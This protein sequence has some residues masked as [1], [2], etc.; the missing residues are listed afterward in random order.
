MA[1]KTTLTFPNGNRY[2]GEINENQRP[3]GQGKMTYSNGDTYAGE[4]KDGLKHGHGV[5]TF[6][7]GETFEGE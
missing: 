3:H 5:Y 7:D 1:Q 2:E 4:W 6:T